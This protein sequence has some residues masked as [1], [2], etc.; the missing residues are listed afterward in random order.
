MRAIMVMYDTLNKHFLPSYGCQETIMPNFQRLCEKSVTFDH[1]YCASLPCMPSRREL[2]TGRPNFLHRGWG[3]IEPF[4][5]S[6]PELLK[7]HN[8]YSHIVSDHKH[9]WTDGGATY[10]TRYSSWEAVRGQSGDAYISDI[11]MKRTANIK[12]AMFDYK[13]PMNGE[14]R[15]NEK[16]NRSRKRQEKDFPI[17]QTFA[18]GLEFLQTNIDQDNWFLQI[19]T[20]DPHEP[21]Y[22][23]K[24]YQDLYDS[25]EISEYSKDF[26]MYA[27]VLEHQEG[28]IERLR[29][30]YFA[31]LSMCDYHL[32]LVLD[33]MD[34]HDMWKD[35]MLIVN[36][37]HGFMLG[38][39]DW[40]GKNI[41][42]PYNE[43]ANIPLF[44]WDPRF[45]ICGERRSQLTQTIDLAPTLLEFFGVDIPKDMRGKPLRPVIAEGEKIH[46]FGIYG[47][48]GVHVSITDGR[49]V[50]MRAPKEGV[51]A[52]EYT[53]MPT[54]MNARIKQSDLA[55]TVLQEPFSFTKGLQTLRMVPEQA[56]ESKQTCYRFGS[57][58]FDL[59]NDP[60]QICPYVD[61]EKET[62][63]V[64][65]MR[66]LMIE[67]DAPVEQYER[68]RMHHDRDLTIEEVI[69]QKEE[70][71]RLLQAVYLQEY[72]WASE[73][74]LLFKSLLPR[75]KD[76]DDLV[77]IDRLKALLQEKQ[78][79]VVTKETVYQLAKEYLKDDFIKAHLTLEI[80]SRTE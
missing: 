45:G 43:I 34:A 20:F 78:V 31:V 29:K 3:P 68:L 30:K 79:T 35:T 48:F 37:D 18:K 14:E 73:A 71:A 76:V 42:L 64:N 60:E 41:M 77:M 61:F 80:A 24:K 33:Y 15:K 6:M 66:R 4:D 55:N 58:L 11:D 32:G 49:Y 5:D 65:A 69:A 7:E 27:A 52:T 28:Y 25:F 21:F 40:I 17:A 19:E 9:Y 26:P 59:E 70:E 23:P 54:R 36:T 47:Y 56:S 50:Y 38:E 63:L 22:A 1:H 2:H 75:V 74:F 46:D 10:H 62:E 51:T 72:T 16:A 12:E 13:L 8:V 44:V 67:N 39:H 57:M 53:L